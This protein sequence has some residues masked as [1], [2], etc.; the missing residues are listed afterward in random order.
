MTLQE[1]ILNQKPF[2]CHDLNVLCKA[3]V[4]IYDESWCNSLIW[5]LGSIRS[6]KAFEYEIGSWN[7]PFRPVDNPRLERKAYKVFRKP[8]IDLND[9]NKKYAFEF[10][11]SWVP[12]NQWITATVSS[13]IGLTGIYHEE[14]AKFH[15]L[16]DTEQAHTYLFSRSKHN[17][18]PLYDMC[19]CE[20]KATNFITID[21]IYV[22]PTQF[23][24]GINAKEIY[25]SL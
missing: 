12:T 16:C 1:K 4:D 15:L 6:L 14:F 18:E 23:M 3:I 20:V 24:W 21:L 2:D 5:L 7:V 8:L 11:Q 9:Q 17:L 19:I 25:I 22:P 13:S 10:H